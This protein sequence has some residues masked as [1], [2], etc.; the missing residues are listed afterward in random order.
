[1]IQDELVRRFPA[2]KFWHY[3]HRVTDIFAVAEWRKILTAEHKGPQIGPGKCLAS[4]LR[5]L[6]P[7]NGKIGPRN[8]RKL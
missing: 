5:V 6:F 7:K 2:T 4:T 1:M 3:K 8:C